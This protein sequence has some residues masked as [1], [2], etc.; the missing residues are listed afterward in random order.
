MWSALCL[1]HLNIQLLALVNF[2]V[3]EEGS[4]VG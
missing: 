3:R 4:I 1:E 2:R